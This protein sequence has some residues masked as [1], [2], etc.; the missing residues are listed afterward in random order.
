MQFPPPQASTSYGTSN[1]SGAGNIMLHQQQLPQHQGR[2]RPSLSDTENRAIKHLDTLIDVVKFNM[3]KDKPTVSSN[4]AGGGGRE[5]SKRSGGVDLFGSF[6]TNSENKYDFFDTCP[7]TQCIIVPPLPNTR[8]PI[9]PED[10]PP[11]GKKEWP[12]KWWGIVEPSEE[13]TA[14]HERAAEE[15]GYPVGKRQKVSPR[16]GGGSTSMTSAAAAASGNGVVDTS[17]SAKNDS[18]TSQQ[19][20]QK[21]REGSGSQQGSRD[22]GGSNYRS[23]D[24]RRRPP[25][26]EHPNSRSLPGNRAKW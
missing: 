1:V 16:S 12:L 7:H 23:Q 21:Q 6:V 3:E 19:H 14:L 15:L 25:P 26:R 8:I 13:L 11:N 24:D 9:F 5:S 4:T 10:F 20:Q 18:R 2:H 17:T 22:G